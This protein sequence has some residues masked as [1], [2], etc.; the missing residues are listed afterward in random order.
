MWNSASSHSSGLMLAL[1]D[2]TSKATNNV[3]SISTRS[4]IVQKK[5]VVCHFT[6]TP[7]AF[8]FESCKCVGKLCSLFDNLVVHNLAIKIWSFT[9]NCV[10]SIMFTLYLFS[11]CEHYLT[12]LLHH[13]NKAIDIQRIFLPTFFFLIKM[14]HWMQITDSANK[15][16]SQTN[17]NY[18]RH[19]QK[20]DNCEAYPSMTFF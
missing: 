12:T 1:L 18:E 19:N 14:N 3:L 15:K 16:K 20:V 11:V 7:M 9:L 10:H 2:P 13:L 8:F 17:Y 4:L 5:C 6:K